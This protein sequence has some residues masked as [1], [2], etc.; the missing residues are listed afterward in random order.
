MAIQ[1]TL[2]PP[3]AQAAGARPDLPD[4]YRL[5]GRLR[6]RTDRPVLIADDA[7]LGHL[8]ALKS[9]P[10]PEAL[11]REA[12]VLEALD[13]P[14]IVRLRDRIERAG[15]C[16]LVLDYIAGESLEARLQAGAMAASDVLR[17]LR[18]LAEAVG[19]IHARGFLHRDLK[20]ANVLIRPSG[21][22]VLIDLGAAAPLHDAPLPAA[23]SSLTEG[24][25]A[26][27]QYL[28][29]PAEGPW[30]DIYALGAIGLR[31]ISGSAPPPA[32]RRLDGVPVPPLGLDPTDPLSRAIPAA[33]SLGAGERPQ[34]IR[35]FL[36]MLESGD[37]PSPEPDEDE[38]PPTVR[39][40]RRARPRPAAGTG[41]AAPEPGPV[42]RRRWPWLLVGSLVVLVAGVA[43]AAVGL[44]PLY[45][46]HF[47]TSWLV[48][49]SGEGDAV[50]IGEAL[51]RAGE[52]AR[53]LIRPGTYHESLVLDG[54]FHLAA[55]GEGEMP[56][57]APEA[58]PCLL[59]TASGGSV[60]GL[61]F[62]GGETAGLA[63]LAIS[64]GD[65]RVEASRI[66]A[67]SGPALEVRAGAMPTIQD[68]EIAGGGLVVREG[69]QP[70]VA[71]TTIAAVSGPAITVRSGAAPE[72]V[73]SRIERSGPVVF[74]EGAGGRFE[75]NRIEGALT[76]GIEIG[77]G[78]APV[79]AD[80]EIAAAGEAGIFVYDEGAG[81]IESNRVSGSRLS[82]IVLA[83]GA[84]SRLSGN[85]IDAS[86]EH[87]ILVL[88]GADVALQE[89][90]VEGSRGFGIAI[91]P[92]AEADLG[93]NQLRANAS[94]GVHDART[95][96]EEADG[97]A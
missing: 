52:G 66:S 63:C 3:A 88:E 40:E 29:A 89:N 82:G 67:A 23:S 45:D 6:R 36:I 60:R 49:P 46:R 62:Q 75:R 11:R 91:A 31:A 12:E 5:R 84:A 13:D 77:S 16:W 43:A 25:A 7:A 1:S 58:G 80:N 2:D 57:I 93:A 59:T 21:E 78:A 41:P 71:S 64:G 47:K 53:I 44:R 10:D 20:P 14:R 26:P 51:D 35:D 54:A 97:G 27:E 94:G 95:A 15:Q 90:L 48:D 30:T 32:L 17:L 28:D 8:V 19:Q 4:R 9:G 65:L 69:A 87:G 92:G 55:A 81:S 68:S 33:M 70:V 22:P 61:A 79:V 56:L 85:R 83:E 74:A 76:N 24:Y 18:D 38:G 42:R 73:E 96:G 34:H 72:I 37:D 39:I 86:G 50:T